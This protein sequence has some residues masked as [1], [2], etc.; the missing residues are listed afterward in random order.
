M[1]CRRKRSGTSL[2]HIC[3]FMK[4]ILF[5]A[6]FLAPFVSEAQFGNLINKAKNK[7]QQRI[8]NKVDKAMDQEL[9]K[10]EGKESTPSSGG[11]AAVAATEAAPAAGSLVSYSKYDFVPGEKIIYTE[12][13]SQDAIGELPLNW[14]TSGKAEVVTLSSFGGRWLRFYQNALYLTANKDSFT[15]N[16][17][18]E[19]DV[20]LQMKPNGWLYPEFEF[21]FLSTNDEPTTDNLFLREYD[22]YAAVQ[23]SLHL[24][25]GGNTRTQVESYF[26]NKKIFYSRWYGCMGPALQQT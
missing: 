1:H 22:K 16:F 21:G 24:G 8:D 4:K 15:R 17:T 20:I 26:E 5:A 12:D 23:A 3:L 6:L 7:V 18:V 25:E 2:R 9:D 14:N 10:V 13:F 19:F 11:S